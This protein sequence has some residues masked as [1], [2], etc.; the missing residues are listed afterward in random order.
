MARRSQTAS[1]RSL[2]HFDSEITPTSH[3]RAAGPA[4]RA[5][6]ARGA[7][8]RSTARRAPGRGEPGR[9]SKT[10]AEMLK[11]W[12]SWGF[13]WKVFLR[14]C[15]MAKFLPIKQGARDV[16]LEELNGWC[17]FGGPL[18]QPE[19]CQALKARDPQKGTHPR[20]V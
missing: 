19:V 16:S 1:P 15:T 9:P 18:N 3:P 2:G 11:A 20:I 12:P 8:G 13:S 7:P 10:C 14:S 5:R 6:A 17:P 4:L